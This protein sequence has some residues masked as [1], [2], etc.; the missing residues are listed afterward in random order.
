MSIHDGI[1]RDPVDTTAAKV[2]SKGTQAKPFRT[3][4]NLRS[5][6]TCPRTRGIGAK[7]KDYTGLRF[8]TLTV[9]GLLD[10]RKTRWIVRCDCGLYEARKPQV[11]RNPSDMDCCHQCQAL[12]NATRTAR[13]RAENNRA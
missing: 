2:V 8:G 13:W 12:R 10:C 4:R 11:M 9:V 6:D 7:Y 1:S 5:S 3:P